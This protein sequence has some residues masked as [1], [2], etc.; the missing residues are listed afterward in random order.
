MFSVYCACMLVLAG[1]LAEFW[2]L[3][4]V[5]GMPRAMLLAGFVATPG[6]VVDGQ[7]IN[8]LG[9]TGDVPAMQKP[10]NTVRVL[11]L[12]S[13]SL[14]NRHLGERL[15]KNLQ[16]RT[17]KHIELLDA[18]IRSHTSRADTVKWQMLATYQW[19]YVL[20]YN[21]INDLWA[22]HV[23]PQDY[24]EDYAHLDPW[25]RRNTWLDH[26][27]VLRYGYNMGWQLLR[28]VNRRTD[29][30][31]FPDYQFVFP[32]KPFVNAAAFASLT[33]YHNNMGTLI[34]QI[35]DQHA[36]AVLLTLAFHLPESYSRQAFIDNALGYNNPDQYDKRDVYNW[37]PPDYVR[38]GLEKENAIVR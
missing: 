26:S 25:N 3:P 10:D 15:K 12:G 27:V 28:D 36:T 33:T 5:T 16:Q 18:G 32:K 1:V 17:D 38:E 20:I 35:A 4:A 34:R 29:E 14:F 9:F 8:A 24:R 11:L 13:S 37:G 6:S 7:K 22:N 2:I 21:G 31:L 23:L 19:D 30:K